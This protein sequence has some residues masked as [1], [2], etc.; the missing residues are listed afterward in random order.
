VIRK[1]T[2]SGDGHALRQS[3]HYDSH[4][5]VRRRVDHRNIVGVTVGNVDMFAIGGYGNLGGDIPDWNRRRDCVAASVD[6]GDRISAVIGHLS[7]LAV[8]RNGHPLGG[9]PNR[10]TGHHGVCCCGN[11]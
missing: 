6:D 7:V 9:N 8:R 10:N 3:A 5:R 2:V 11:H 4:H 1:A